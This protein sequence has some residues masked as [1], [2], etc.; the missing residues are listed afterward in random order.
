MKKIFNVFALLLTAIGISS[1]GND[2]ENI[3]ETKG[4]LQLEMETIASTNTR[5]DIMDAPSNYDSKT[6]VVRILDA[7]SNVVKESTW[8]DGA[9]VNTEFASP[10]M[11]TPG[12]YTVEAHSANWDGSGSGW[13]AAYYA[14]TTTTTVTAGHLAKAKLKLTQ[15][16]VKVDVIWDQSFRDNFTTAKATVS[17]ENNDEVGSRVFNM[18]GSSNGAAYFPVGNLEWQLTATN[19]R[20]V[21]H[22]T[23]NTITDVKARDYFR[24]KFSVAEA[25]TAGSIDVYLDETT[26]TYT[27]NI[28]VPRESTVSLNANRV[29]TTEAAAT[30]VGGSSA[31]LSGS[32]AGK[33]L[34]KDKLFLQYRKKSEETWTTIDNATLTAASAI[35]EVS[36][37][38]EVSYKVNGLLAST[39]YEYQLAQE[40]EPT[41][42]SNTVSFTIEGEALYNGGFE[43]WHYEGKNEIAYPTA[44][45]GIKY[46][47]SSNPG[48]GSVTKSLAKLTDKT[49]EQVHGG[50]Y[51]AKLMSKA[52]MGIL[53]A[54][55]LYTGEFGNLD[56]ASQAASLK[57]GVPFTARPASL[58][59][60]MMYKPGAVNIT[61]TSAKDGTPLP[62]DAPGSGEPDH[63]H[64]FCALM[65]IDSPLEVNNGDLSTFPTW[66]NRNDPR[67]VAYGIKVQ[68]TTQNN[69]VEFDIPL[70]YYQTNVKPKYLIIVAAA[71]KYGDYFHGSSS[72][73]LYLD[74]LELRY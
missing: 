16:N 47:S 35:T 14:G 63:S 52:T 22:D 12:T 30:I 33:D 7:Q 71:S 18:T 67:I 38:V 70:D 10:I 56:V 62:S 19:K 55:S 41:V 29:T 66:T 42:T 73:V 51:A 15:D 9:F 23:S 27:I 31:V 34:N 13:N 5:A 25:G 53:A 48:S 50:T 60:Y 54:A 69:W 58:H 45:E 57:W 74:D 37:G 39:P 21:R 17:M 26:R 44:S 4:Y 8:K 61:A 64:I 6:L 43:L 3:E 40:G 32:A 49:T 1:C 65:N 20:G 28:N 36:S 72:S 68:K 59:G 24:I 46:W 11:L 2:M